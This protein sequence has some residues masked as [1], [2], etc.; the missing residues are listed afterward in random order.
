MCEH[1]PIPKFTNYII[2]KNILFLIW[3]LRLLKYYLILRDFAEFI[4]VINFSP[5]ITKQLAA[6]WT[7]QSY[8]LLLY[9]SYNCFWYV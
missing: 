9:G 8:I 7:D 6:D 1:V 2:T 5:R 3:N 4:E